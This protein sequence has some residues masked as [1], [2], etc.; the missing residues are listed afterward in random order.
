MKAG[1]VPSC[2]IERLKIDYGD[3]ENIDKFQQC[4]NGCLNGGTLVLYVAGRRKQL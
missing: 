4:F 2:Y 1:L 3:G